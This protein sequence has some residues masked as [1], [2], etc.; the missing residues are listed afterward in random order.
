MNYKKYFETMGICLGIG[1]LS[2]LVTSFLLTILN[3]FNLVTGTFFTILKLFIPF[4][5]LLIAGILLGKKSK[6]KGW[7][8][9]LKLSLGFII[10]FTLIQLFFLEENVYAF[11][12]SGQ[13]PF[14][15]GERGLQFMGRGGEKSRPAAVGFPFPLHLSLQAKIGALQLL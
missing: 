9:G 7:L 15:D 3:Y 1:L 11:Q 10:I 14:Q 5:S 2:M 12:H 6:S 13:L 8:E 4:L